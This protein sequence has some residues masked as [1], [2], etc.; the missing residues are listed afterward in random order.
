MQKVYYLHDKNTFIA[1]ILPYYR[2]NQKIELYA[3][4]K[5]TL[6]D[7]CHTPMQRDMKRQCGIS[8]EDAVQYLREKKKG[9]GNQ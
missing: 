7:E 4:K 3:G 2:S 5:K 1:A 8:C 6:D 9:K